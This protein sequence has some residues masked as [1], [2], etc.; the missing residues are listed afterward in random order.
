MTSNHLVWTSEN[1]PSSNIWNM[2]SPPLIYSITKNRWSRVWKQ[3]WRD[4][5][6]GG[7]PR[8]ARTLLSLRVHSTSSSCTTKSFFND[9]IAYTSLDALCSARNTCSE[10]SNR[11]LLLNNCV[12]HLLFN[13]HTCTMRWNKYVNIVHITHTHTHIT[14]TSHTHTPFQMILC[15]EQLWV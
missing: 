4:V 2:R 5:R 12:F 7:L 3:E 6:K 1:R 15:Q 8:R 14:H 9:F 13:I 10:T 11:S